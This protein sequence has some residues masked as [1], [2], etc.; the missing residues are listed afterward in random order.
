MKYT[1]PVELRGYLRGFK[2]YTDRWKGSV[3]TFYKTEN[4]N[5]T[6]LGTVVKMTP[7]QVKIL[8]GYEGHPTF[9]E[10][11]DLSV[12]AYDIDEETGLYT[13]PFELDT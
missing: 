9:Y 4:P 11:I 7:E 1:L 6:V 5:D 3:A 10:R 12:L 8:D 2:G 13:R